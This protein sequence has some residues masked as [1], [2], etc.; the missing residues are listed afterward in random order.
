MKKLALI[1]F[2]CIMSF[3]YSKAQVTTHQYRTVKQADMQEYLKRETTY[4]QKLVE[5]EVTKGN[6][7]F[8]GIFVKVGGEDLENTPNVLIINTFNDIDTGNNF[9]GGVAD[10]FPDVDM[11]NIQTGSL[12][13]TNST[14]YISMLGNHTTAENVAE[15]DFNFVHIIY[16]NSKDVG[17]HLQAEQEEWKPF[18]QNAMNTGK[19]TMKGWGNGRI[20]SPESSAFPYASYSYDLFS[21]MNDALSDPFSEDLEFPDGF[22]DSLEGNYAGPRDSHL[23][24]IIAVVTPP[25]ED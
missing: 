22:L 8:W 4:W 5:T 11:D 20:V 7:I 3:Q 6:L 9:W 12:S 14:I 2:A 16:H 21:S 13:T 23:Y 25:S 1:L 17:I 18:V 19:T 10:L 15:N 24:R